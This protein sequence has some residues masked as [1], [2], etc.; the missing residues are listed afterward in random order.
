[1]LAIVPAPRAGSTNHRALPR[2][3]QALPW[4]PSLGHALHV[5]AELNCTWP[6]KGG[7]LV[8]DRKIPAAAHGW[9]QQEPPG[10]CQP[11]SFCCCL[12][13]CEPCSDCCCSPAGYNVSVVI[14][15]GRRSLVTRRGGGGE[16][17]C[18]QP[19]RASS[20]QSARF[21]EDER[22]SVKTCSLLCW[23]GSSLGCQT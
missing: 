19:C 12:S 4:T 1:M 5:Q 2:M 21:T 3:G 6:R 16:L 8:F 14:K 10:P 11:S 18:R 15:S 23:L 9:S 17:C 13:L 20:E 22:C 7:S